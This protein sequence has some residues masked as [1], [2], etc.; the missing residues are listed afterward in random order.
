MATKHELAMQV[1]A[2]LGRP[3]DDATIAAY[4]VLPMDELQLQADKLPG[5]VERLKAEGHWNVETEAMQV[6]LMDTDECELCG[7][8]AD[9][10]MAQFQDDDRTEVVW[11]H[12]GCGEDAGLSM[13]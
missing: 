11:C 5:V 3:N 1:A 2:A 8:P 12:A 9:S 13:C 7:E 4:Q 10:E 6:S